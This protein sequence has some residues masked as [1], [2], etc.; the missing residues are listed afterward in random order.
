[1]L[2]D[3]AKAI[4]LERTDHMRDVLHLRNRTDRSTNRVLI[5]ANEIIMS[6]SVHVNELFL[7]CFQTR[8]TFNSTDD[9][10]MS[11]SVQEISY[12]KRK[13]NLSNV[14]MFLC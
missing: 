7:G 5:A 6:S 2:S 11:S 13:C 10:H 9:A 12:R 14:L 4:L 1:M 3:G 8:T